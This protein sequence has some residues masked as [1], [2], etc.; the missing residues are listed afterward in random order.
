MLTNPLVI[1]Y[2]AHDAFAFCPA[3]WY[4]KYIN[5]RRKRWPPGQRRDALALGSLVHEGLRMWQQEHTI[6]IP[7]EVVEEVTPDRETY[8]LAQEL[9]L[10]YAR[11]YPS[12]LW[13]LVM[14]EEPLTW[15]IRDEH[16]TSCQGDGYG[17]HDIVPAIYGLAKLDAYF[18]VPEPTEIE[19]GQ[20]GLTFTLSKG[21]W[22]QEYKTKSPRIA[23]GL[24]MQAWETNLQASYQ[25]L[26]L[27]AELKRVFDASEGEHVVQ[28]VLVNVLEKP[29]RYIPKRKCNACQ[30]MYEYS[31]W[32]PTGTG[33]YA[34][35]VCGT[36]RKIEPL[37][38]NV[39]EAPPNY[40]RIVVTRT[41]EDLARDSEI[42][43]QVAEQMLAMRSG[44]LT[45]APWTKRNCVSLEYRRACDYYNPHKYGNSTLDDDVEYE[46]PQGD[47]RG[48]VQ[49]E[50]GS[51]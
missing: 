28:G 35:P 8:A 13:P 27:N 50:G 24:Y 18:Y 11:S 9:V 26:A 40:F 4:E 25:C 1:D 12:E 44:G 2:S 30:E 41:A 17:E 51:E 6:E 33:E 31:T 29:N 43:H 20:P 42:I 47:Y 16:C 32:L 38:A 7:S 22:A 10:G 21:W 15:Q 19:S 45:S 36:R 34:C 14:C 39:P 3:S 5:K 49:L 23:L 48:L 37:R 46:T